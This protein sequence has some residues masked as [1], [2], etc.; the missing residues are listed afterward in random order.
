RRDPE[1][2]VPSSEQITSHRVGLALKTAENLVSH[3]EGLRLR[4]DLP[5]QLR[6]GSF[7][8]RHGTRL[9]RRG[10][11]SRGGRCDPQAPPDPPAHAGAASFPLF[12]P[13][14]WETKNG[15]TPA[16]MPMP[17]PTATPRDWMAR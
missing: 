1:G 11:A 10:R 4:G 9:H 14:R 6:R 17:T 5:G 13:H 16:R 3:L 15:A 12:R 2:P 8:G 7:G